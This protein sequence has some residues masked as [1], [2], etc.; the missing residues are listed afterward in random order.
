MSSNELYK[1]YV[2]FQPGWLGL[3]QH[4]ETCKRRAGAGWAARSAAAALGEVPTLPWPAP[5]ASPSRCSTHSG[6]AQITH[7]R[8]PHR[9]NALHFADGSIERVM[10]ILAR[11]IA[12]LTHNV[13]KKS[14]NETVDGN[15]EARLPPFPHKLKVGMFGN[16]SARE[17]QCKRKTHQ[18]RHQH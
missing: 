15:N 11:R 18:T 7:D 10:K 1:L 9:R 12:P 3:L 13:W 16:D 8:N 6:A 2:F 4:P 17:K 14:G 5:R